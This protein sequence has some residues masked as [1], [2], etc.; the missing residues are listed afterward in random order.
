MDKMPGII[1]AYGLFCWA[2]GAG[3]GLLWGH[4]FWG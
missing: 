4:L 2:L 3:V 1:I